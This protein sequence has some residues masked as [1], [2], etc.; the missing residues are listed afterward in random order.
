[1]APHKRAA[2]L[3]HIAS[4][5]ISQQLLLLLVGKEKVDEDGKEEKTEENVNS[6]RDEED[7]VVQKRGVDCERQ[8]SG[9]LGNNDLVEILASL[10]LLPGIMDNVLDS[11]NAKIGTDKR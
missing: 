8:D 7:T 4:V 11:L 9:D 1:M 3:V 6:H 10:G 5:I 2:S